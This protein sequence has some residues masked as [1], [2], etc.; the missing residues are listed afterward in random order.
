MDY[1]IILDSFEGPLDLLLN[2]IE[3]SKIDIYDIPI[4]LIT[5]QYLDYIYGMEEF[6]LEV[7]SDFLVMAAT[8]L[9]IKSKLL[10]PKIEPIDED[11]ALEDPRDELVQRLLAYKKYKEVAN[12]LREYEEIGL[13]SFCKPQEDLSQFEEQELEIGP[14]D[15]ESLFK[16]LNR[17]LER[18]GLDTDYLNFEE[19]SRDEFTIEEC[20]ENIIQR[21][22]FKKKISFSELLKINS[23]KNEI[24]AYFLSLL[25]LMKFKNISVR[26][27]KAFSDIIIVR[28]D[29]GE[30]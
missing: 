25:E 6:N 2:L 17:I 19:I 1:K 10:L 21:L 13:K 24:V 23:S 14:L 4:N 8:L 3:K 11:E 28:N 22:E 20:T 18:R 5:E 29:M 15:I 12:R 7:T 16:T 27:D 30:N 26:Q 9:H